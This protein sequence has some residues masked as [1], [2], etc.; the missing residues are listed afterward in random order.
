[1]PGKSA[2]KKA[3][4]RRADWDGAWKEALQQLLPDF[5]RLLF[6][7]VHALID[8]TEPPVFLEQE[9][10]QATRRARRRMRSVDKLVRVRLLGGGQATLLVHVE[11]QNEVDTDL[12]A[13]L[14]LYNIRIY[15]LLG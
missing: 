7:A 6:P 13:R 4:T 10:R 9:L 12:V 15:S 1:M 11:F 14:Y 3:S 2:A 8:G 5:L